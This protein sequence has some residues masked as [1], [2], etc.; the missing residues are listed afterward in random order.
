MLTLADMAQLST[1]TPYNQA[2]IYAMLPHSQLFDKLPFTDVGDIN[3]MVMEATGLP[4]PSHRP[5]NPTAVNIATAK[6]G[7]RPESLKIITDKITVDR[8]L[9]GNK[10]S[11]VDPRT[12]AI[13]QYMKAIGYEM[14]NMFLNGNPITAPDQPGGL[15]YRFRTDLRLSNGTANPAT[16][17]Q[18]ID[19][20]DQNRDLTVEANAFDFLDDIHALMS[21]IDGGNP[22]C[23]LTNRQGWLAIGRAVRRARMFRHDQDAFGRPVLTFGDGGP[24]VIDTGY[25]P[26]G[27]LDRSVQVLPTATAAG[28]DLTTDAIYAVKFGDTMVGALQKKAPESIEFAENS[29]DFPYVVSSYEHVYGFQLTNPFSVAVL[30]R[31]F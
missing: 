28:D 31:A 20:N 5:I 10:S 26:A 12:A 15:A 23:L 14:V 7:Q 22:D 13:E 8:Q 2:V 29:A 11:H 16:Q 19:A 24:V 9:L 27:A 25:T 1:L 3:T 21:L 18:V 6:F 4:V 30:R 17:K